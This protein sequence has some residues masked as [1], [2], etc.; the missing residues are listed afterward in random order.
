MASKVTF[1]ALSD[2]EAEEEEE[3]EKDESRAPT[4][5]TQTQLDRMEANRKRALEIRQRKES[6]S[7]LLVTS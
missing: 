2:E 5:L 1:H 3:K 7:K 4:Q 6:A